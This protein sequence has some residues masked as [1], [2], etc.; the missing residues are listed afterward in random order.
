M[1]ISEMQLVMDR[2]N[3]PYTNF[4]HIVVNLVDSGAI[5]FDDLYEAICKESNVTINNITI[6][7]VT[8]HKYVAINK[9]EGAIQAIKAIRSAYDLGLREAKEFNDVIRSREH[10]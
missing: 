8:Y 6:P 1:T 4:K 9:N 7:E 3:N 5:S 2:L 10:F